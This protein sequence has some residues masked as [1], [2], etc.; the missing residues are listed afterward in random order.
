M[1]EEEYEDCPL[2]VV[3]EMEIKSRNNFNKFRM[4]E[5]LMNGFFD[6]AKEY[7]L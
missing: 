3:D 2:D 4:A 7:D 1:D 5:N 6:K